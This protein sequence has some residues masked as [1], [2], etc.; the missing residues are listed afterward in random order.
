MIFTEELTMT[1]KKVI[2]ILLVDDHKIIRD[3]LKALLRNENDIRIIGECGDGDEVVDFIKT[4]KTDVI[5]MDINMKRKNGIDA[6]QEVIQHYP[7]V[8]VLALSMHN[9][10]SFI[11]RMLKS[12]ASGY[13]LKNIGKAE[14]VSAIENVF[15]GKAHFSKEVSD[16]MINR[17]MRKDNGEDESFKI[18]PEQLTQR[19]L[20]ILKLIASEYTSNE[21]G[22]S[23]NI[24]SRTVDSH[25]RSLLHKI[26][27]KNTVGL[28]KFALHHQL[29]K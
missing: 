16:I 21:I 6:T 28:I 18:T 17:F 25:R 11:S 1:E 10:E 29:I 19:E 20:E 5:L 23:L 15:K 7:K 14:L 24:S 13:V 2:K 22:E 27:V 12:G 8:K 9:E 26:G 3:G 4:H